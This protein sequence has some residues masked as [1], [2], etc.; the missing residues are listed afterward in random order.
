MNIIQQRIQTF[1]CSDRLFD[2]FLLFLSA[3]FAIVAERLY[4]SRSW[5]AL[6]PV[7]FNF[8]ALIIIFI[9]WLILIMVFESDLTYRRTHFW[10]IVKNTTLIS[11]IGVTTTITLDYL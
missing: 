11:F 2:L 7:S 9:I 6:D 1:R 4:H 10:N 3:R 8:Y 5:H